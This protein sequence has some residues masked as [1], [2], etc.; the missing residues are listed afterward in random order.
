M[1]TLVF[2]KNFSR[3]PQLPIG[4]ASEAKGNPWEHA[5]SER[6]DCTLLLAADAGELRLARLRWNLKQAAEVEAPAGFLGL[7]GDP[8]Y[9]DEVDERKWWQKLFRS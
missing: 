8:V 1:K 3:L 2:E 9:L 7:E 5:L 6:R 4:N